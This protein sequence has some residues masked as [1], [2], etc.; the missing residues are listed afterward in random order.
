MVKSTIDKGK[1]MWDEILWKGIP[2]PA[3]KVV[4]RISWRSMR[5][6]IAFSKLVVSNDP[7]ITN[8]LTKL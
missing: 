6:A 1:E 8:A 2:S 7:V 3:S 5:V 4:R